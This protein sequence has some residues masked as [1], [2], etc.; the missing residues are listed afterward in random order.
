M[1]TNHVCL[2]TL[3]GSHA[4]VETHGK[5]NFYA[6]CNCIECTRSSTETQTHTHTLELYELPPMQ[7]G[8]SPQQ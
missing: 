3:T 8:I 1:L 2:F 4:F 6:L 7:T 5:V